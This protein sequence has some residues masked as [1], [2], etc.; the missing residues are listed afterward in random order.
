MRKSIAKVLAPLALTTAFIAVTPAYAADDAEEEKEASGPIDVEVTL[1]AVSDYRFRG[2][3]LSGKDPA[4][5]PSITVTHESGFYVS[6]WGSNI[7]DNGGDDVELDLIAGF[8]GG[9]AL[10]YDL[11]L[12]YYVYPGASAANYAEIIGKLGTTIGP[13]EL[14]GTLA[15]A[16]SQDG[17]GNQDNVYVGGNASL[18][19]PNTPLKLNASLGLEDG[20]F[21]DNKID[22]SLGATV[23]VA[24]FTLGASYV[25]TNRLVGG[26]GNAG[27]VFSVSYTF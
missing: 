8:G 26:L 19:I 5:Q 9:E 6:A 15:Y 13:V 12:T 16:P 10:T 1:A 24:G 27:A 21:G 22:W 23:D 25:D 7:A 2:V 17:T 3:S 14:G 4:F 11:N 20:A 18:G